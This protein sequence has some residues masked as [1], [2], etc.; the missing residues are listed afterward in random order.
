MAT[1]RSTQY[2]NIHCQTTIHLVLYESAALLVGE[3]LS[4][5][6]MR[7][8]HI[9]MLIA[10]QN[11]NKSVTLRLDVVPTLCII[12]YK[13]SISILFCFLKS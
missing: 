3:G 7:S 2:A 1:R 8:F 12:E 11:V 5:L 10:Q 6:V 4:T 9:G 13:S